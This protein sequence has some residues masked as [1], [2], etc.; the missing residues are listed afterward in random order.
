MDKFAP[1]IEEI[2]NWIE[3]TC[4][5][6]PVSVT[7]QIKG[8]EYT[9]YVHIDF[10]SAAD[11]RRSV[12]MH[13]QIRARFT[14]LIMD[15]ERPSGL[16]GHGT[17]ILIRT[18]KVPDVRVSYSSLEAAAFSTAYARLGKDYLKILARR[19]SLLWEIRGYNDMIIFF[20]FTDDQFS[21][22]HEDGTAEKI[23][24]EFLDLLKAHDKENLIT[25]ASLNGFIRFESKET[26]DRDFGG[27][28]WMYFR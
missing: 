2:I 24:G 12:A 13:D 1:A 20:Y 4:S 16:D 10:K 8:T 18:G 5:A 28:E 3:A 11:Y 6:R 26:F 23:I 27:Q 17:V 21:A 22:C 7:F 19:S 9:Q 25:R 15:K 14:Q